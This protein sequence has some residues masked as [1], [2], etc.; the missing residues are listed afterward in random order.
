MFLFTFNFEA[1]SHMNLLLISSIPN[2]DSICQTVVCIYLPWSPMI[3]LPEHMRSPPVFSGVRVTR[4]LGLYVCLVDRCLSFY[5]FSLDHCVVCLSL[6]YAFWLPLWC[7]QP[8]LKLCL[9][10]L[11]LPS[12]DRLQ[13]VEDYVR[14]CSWILNKVKNIYSFANWYLIEKKTAFSVSTDILITFVLWFM[15]YIVRE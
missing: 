11:Y 8:L 12:T 1:R 15:A 3:T 4:S 9:L 5:T 13:Q 2:M 10:L 14:S 7:L 6:I